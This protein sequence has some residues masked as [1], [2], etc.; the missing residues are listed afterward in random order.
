MFD[1]ARMVRVA[2]LFRMGWSM[3]MWFPK[4]DVSVGTAAAFGDR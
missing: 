2:P 1:D 3:W 4:V